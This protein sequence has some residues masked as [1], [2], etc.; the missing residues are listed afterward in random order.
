MKLSAPKSATWLVSVIAG[1][2]GV[3][4]HYRIAHFAPLAPYSVFLIVGAWVLLVLAT[5]LSGL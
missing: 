5:F 3:L 4:L 1:T 2:V